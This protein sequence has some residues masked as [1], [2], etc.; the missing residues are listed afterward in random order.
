MVS[1]TAKF[2]GSTVDWG[3]KRR[4]FFGFRPL[5]QKRCEI[6]LSL[7]SVANRKSYMAYHLS[8]VDDLELT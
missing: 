4:V 1:L 5:F 2:E 7:Q 6:E 3:H 8:K